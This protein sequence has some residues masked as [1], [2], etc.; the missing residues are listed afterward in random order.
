MPKPRG[1]RSA[2]RPFEASRAAGT[3][4]E[5]DRLRRERDEARALLQDLLKKE[6]DGGAV[7]ARRLA[8]L[9]EERMV[10]RGQ[11]VEAALA[12]GRAEA[13]L[14]AL[15]DAI[16]RAPGIEGWLLR[17]AKRKVIL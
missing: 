7:L 1:P 14:K 11:A 8:A 13:A 3:T 10:A 4:D 2:P 17:R 9:E 15:S 6:G 16:D 5:L 12:R